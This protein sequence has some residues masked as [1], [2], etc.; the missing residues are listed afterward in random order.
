MYDHQEKAFFK[1]V[2]LNADYAKSRVNLYSCLITDKIAA[3][4]NLTAD[5][6]LEAYQKNELKGKLKEIA[7]GLDEEDNPVLMLIKHRK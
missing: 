4:Q 6:L 5:Q 1:P 2:V 3:C 7:A